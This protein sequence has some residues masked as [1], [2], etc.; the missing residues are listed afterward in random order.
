MLLFKIWVE[1]DTI[2]FE[3]MGLRVEDGNID[4]IGLSGYGWWMAWG[5]GSGCR[6]AR[7]ATLCHCKYLTLAL[8]THLI[9]LMKNSHVCCLLEIRFLKVILFY[10]GDLSMDKTV[11]KCTFQKQL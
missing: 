5:D 9:M 11:H 4:G 3:M 2:S 8:K 6:E 7:Y 1:T 10:R